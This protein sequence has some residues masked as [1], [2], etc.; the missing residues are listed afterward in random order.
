MRLATDSFLNLT[1]L[2]SC[3]VNNFYN[4]YNLLLNKCISMT[5]SPEGWQQSASTTLIKNGAKIGECVVGPMGRQSNRFCVVRIRG[6]R[7][8]GALTVAPS[9]WPSGRQ[10]SGTEAVSWIL[11][12]S[13]TFWHLCVMSM[14]ERPLNKV[15]HLKSVEFSSNVYKCRINSFWKCLFSTCNVKCKG[16]FRPKVMNAMN[17]TRLHTKSMWRPD[18]TQCLFGRVWRKERKKVTSVLL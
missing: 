9:Q 11:H 13:M 14:I 16:V 7:T 8:S 2:S 6:R 3:L 4:D 15:S 1:L 17:A 12:W 18:Y 5:L 10:F